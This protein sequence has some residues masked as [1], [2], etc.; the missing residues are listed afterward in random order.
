LQREILDYFKKKSLERNTQFLI[1]THAE[2]FIRGVDVSQIVSLLGQT[3]SRI[4]STPEIIRA[5]ADVS[6]EEYTR[7]LTSPYILY[8]EGESDER[9]LRAW[10]EQCRAQSAIDKVCF[11]TMGGGGKE[12]MKIRADEHFAALKQLIPTIVRLMLFDYDNADLAFHPDAKNPTLAEWN[13]KN[14]ENYLLV[15]D[16][17]K[18]ATLQQM[19]CAETDLFAQS[20]L[21]CIDEF[22]TG[23][24]LTLPPGKTWHS[25]TA[26]IFRVVDGKRILFENK[27]SLFHQLRNGSSLEL[28]RE[29]VAM[30]MCAD[31]IHEDVHQF[32]NKLIAMTGI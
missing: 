10:A 9:I 20:A 23:Q 3:S 27:E 12:N 6:N 18:R 19:E 21:K 17:W 26:D 13:R 15:P 1:A 28:Q 11:K 32:M 5:M 8:V 16:A 29:K 2:E 24:N 31:E 7:L 22:F 14:I 30:L 4:Q 25:V